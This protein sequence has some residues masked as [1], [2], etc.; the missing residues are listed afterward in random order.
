MYRI[1]TIIGLACMAVPA[2]AGSSPEEIIYISCRAC[3]AGPGS[4]TTIPAI[5]GRPSAELSA[6]LSH[7]AQDS[8]D[9]VIMHRFTTGLTAD[10]LTALAHYISGL[11][12]DG[13]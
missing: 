10:E 13:Q 1:L 3:H 7:I 12:G 9:T 6:A 8:H 2:H 4:D 5:A 11:E